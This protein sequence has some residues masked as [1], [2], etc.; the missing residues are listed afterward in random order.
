MQG[1]FLK[2][3]K[4]MSR[5]GLMLGWQVPGNKHFVLKGT[6]RR[7][8]GNSSSRASV[9]SHKSIV[10]SEA[11]NLKAALFPGQGTTALKFIQGFEGRSTESS[12]QLLLQNPM[13]SVLRICCISSS[14]AQRST[15]TYIA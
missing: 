10:L 8:A 1:S 5:L 9:V 6:L 4:Q 14:L 7:S 11:V 12:L 3:N 2:E 13:L 15:F